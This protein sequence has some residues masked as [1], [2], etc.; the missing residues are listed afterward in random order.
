[1][2]SRFLSVLSLQA[3]DLGLKNLQC[4]CRKKAKQHGSQSRRLLK[5]VHRGSNHDLRTTIQ[6]EPKDPRADG[7]ES[8]RGKVLARSQLQGATIAGCQ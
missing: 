6:R 7:W 1:M 5:K 2:F 8:N 4:I 3:C